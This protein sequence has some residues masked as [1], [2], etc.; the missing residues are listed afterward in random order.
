[1]MSDDDNK[2]PEKLVEAANEV[3]AN[4]TAREA[5]VLREKLGIN[6]SSEHTLEEVAAQFD[7]VRERIQQIEEKAL[8]KLARKKEL[9]A[10][11]KCSFCKLRSDQVKRL[12]AAPDSDVFI[13][14]G[15]VRE[16]LKILEE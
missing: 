7:L 15:C 2:D 14:D 1:M 13:C 5:K 16:C 11:P 4:L 10:L 12:I 9:E 6:L 3:L 8:K